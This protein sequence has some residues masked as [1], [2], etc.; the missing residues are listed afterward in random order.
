[1][2][3]SC[4]SERRGSGG[5]I[6]QSK[7]VTTP[8]WLKIG[9]LLFLILGTY[10]VLKRF[11]VREILNPTQITTTLQAAGPFGPVLFILLMA[12][13]VIISPIPSLPLDLAA[14]ATFGVGLG[15]TYAVIGAEIGAV[16]SFLIGRTV[17]REA[18]TRLIRINIVFCER[19]SD[20][21]LAVFVFASRLLPIFS[22]D[23]ISYGAG[24][25]NM[26]LR[27][28]ALATLLG[29]IG[30][31]FLLTYAGEQVVSGEWVLVVLGIAM[32]VL[33]LFLPKAIVRYPNARW[34]QFLR[35]GAPLANPPGALETPSA[36]PCS[37]CG[38]P[39]S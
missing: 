3:P 25:T 21:H 35:G 4:G 9:G 24:L 13:A 31:T 33:L 5:A 38:S 34:V 12:T 29:T 1:M 10:L 36:V 14:G 18:L 16:V 19:C 39:L 23:L 20:R 28:F 7:C 26:S 6:M 27:A 17:G 2:D 11:E 32:V 37:S 22:F 8:H 15:T 30:P